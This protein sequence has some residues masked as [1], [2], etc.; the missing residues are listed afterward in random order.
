MVE[1]VS[2][3]TNNSILHVFVCRFDFTI[4]MGCFLLLCIEAILHDSNDDAHYWVRYLVM[5]RPLKF[6]R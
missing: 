2:D 6:I 3:A 1:L 5:A 4:V